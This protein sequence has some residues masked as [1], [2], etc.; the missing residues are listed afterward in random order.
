MKQINVYRQMLKN[1][2]KEL[3]ETERQKEKLF[4]LLERG[5]YT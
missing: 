1:L 3:D 4:D 2:E 5:I